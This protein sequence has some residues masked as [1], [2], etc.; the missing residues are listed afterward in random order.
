MLTLGQQATQAG[1]S[2]EILNYAILAPQARVSGEN[3]N[4][5]TPALQ[6][7]PSGDIEL[8]R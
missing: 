1:V 2:G 3:L 5:V 4:Y 6:A 7:R 8:I